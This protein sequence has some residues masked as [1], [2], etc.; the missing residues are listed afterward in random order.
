MS[1]APE[2]FTHR[3]RRDGHVELLHH[4]K[5]A[6][7]LRGVAATRFPEDVERDDAQQLMARLTGNHRHGNERS[8]R[9]HPRNRGR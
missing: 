4:G 9:R 1:N 6:G 2:G 7:V 5:P 8:G 3:V